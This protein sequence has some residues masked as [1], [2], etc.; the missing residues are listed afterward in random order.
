MALSGF[1]FLGFRIFELLVLIPILGMLAFFVHG[2]VVSNA[3]TPTYILVL[4]IASVL[5]A[6][7][8]LGTIIT[9]LRARHSAVFVALVDLAFVGTFI[10][11]V[12]LLRGIA[13]ADCVNFT[14]GGFYV[15]LGVFGYYGLQSNNH[16]ALNANKT[17]VMLKACFALG[18]IAII[19]FFITFV[20][21]NLSQRHVSGL[22]WEYI[23]Y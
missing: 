3:L 16:W 6:A 18:I 23:R 21:S 5:G 15:G 8:V 13:K 1:L 20:S 12:Y 2:Y 4:F 10:A 19:L 11:G 22:L 7:W 14:T 17:C 9:Y